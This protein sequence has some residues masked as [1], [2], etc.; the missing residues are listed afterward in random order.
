M[1]LMPSIA[2]LTQAHVLRL[3]FVLIIKKNVFVQLK[4]MFVL[5]LEKKKKKKKAEIT[6]NYSFV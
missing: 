3:K 6:E 2:D 4:F 5:F 1:G